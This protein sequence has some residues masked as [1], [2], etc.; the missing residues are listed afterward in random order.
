M[1]FHEKSTWAI[2]LL[3]AAIGVWYTQKIWQI[4]LSQLADYILTIVCDRRGV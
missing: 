1:T 2:G 4:S 3:I